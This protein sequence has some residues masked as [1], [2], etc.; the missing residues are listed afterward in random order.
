MFLEIFRFECRYQ[1][2]SP[3][4][5]VVAGL[6]F[7]I[8]FL[9]SGTDSVSVGGVGNNINLNANFAILQIQYTLTVLGLFPAVAFV[10]GAITR[11]YEAKTAQLLFASGVSE[12]SY[13]FGRFAGG[14]LFAALV[15]VAGL[16][17]TL[18]GTFMPWL[19]PE[20]MGPFTAAPYLFSIW[21]III[22]NLLII[23][24]LFFAVAALTRS[25]MAAYVAALGFFIAYIVVAN[26]TDQES[27]HL[28]AL[29]DPFGLTAFGEITRY[30]TVF[31]RN[32]GMPEVTSTLL[33]NRL[34]WAGVSLTVL[35]LAAWRYRFNLAPASRLRLRRKEKPGKPA[36][37]A[38]SELRAVQPLESGRSDVTRFFSQLRMDVRGMTRSIPFYVLLAF[39]MLQVVGS[40]IG[41]TTQF[42]GTP[43]YPLT[44]TLITF[45]GGSFSLA[46]IIVIIYYSGELVHRERQA[47]MH[48]IVDA[49]AYPNW[50]MVLSKVAAL[51]FVI[52][53][54][55]VVVMLT[56]MLVQIFNDFYRFE[57]P[58]YFKGLF[59]VLGVSY[60]L[61]CVPAVL[62]QVLSPNKFIGMVVF[63][64][65][66]LGLQTLP[67]LDFEHY[68]YQYATP[69]APY[70]DM[71]G[72]GHF[73]E[74]LVS[75]SIY[76]SALAGLMIVLAHLLFRRG[77]P[78]SARAQLT[79]AGGRWNGVVAGWTAV[80]A[81]VF[82]GCGAWIFYNTNVLN[83]YVTS[84]ARE[85]LQADYEKAYKQFEDLPM[86][87]LVDLEMAVDIYPES[88]RLDSRG[89]ARMV[90]RKAAPIEVLH[91][92]LPPPLTVNR[93]SL[94]GAA[95]ETADEA[96]DYYQYRFEEP[97]APGA[98]TTLE[99][100]LSWINEGFHNTGGT[101]RVVENGTFVNNTEIMP[102]PGYQS[103]RELGDNNVR[104]EYDLPPVER[105]PK[106]GD[107]DHLDEN[108]FTVSKRTAF[109]SVVSTAEDQIAVAPGYLQEE[110]VEGGRRYFAYEMDAPIWPFVS[111]SSARYAV[112]EDQW[113]DVK[114][115]VYYHPAHDFN[116]SNMIEGTKASLDYF[117]REFS[118]YQYRQFRILEFPRYQTFAQSFP[119]TIPYSEAIGF[120]ADLR[121]EKRIDYVFYV[122]AH[123][124]A[125]QWWGHQVVGANMQGATILVETLAQYSAL[126]VMEEAFGE[127]KMRRFLKYELDSYLQSRGSEL[128][129]ELPLNLVENQG[130]I[131]Y[132]KGS[133]AMYALK[134]AIGEDIVNLALR[135]LIA[136]WGFREGLFP[137]S[138]DL[139]AEFRAV[140]GPDHQDLITDL[141]EKIIVY[142]LSVA[143]TEV[144]EVDGGFEVTMIVEAAKFEADGAGQETEVALDQLLDVA[145][146]AEDTDEL[147]E[148]DL[149]P[150]LRFERVR[151]TSGEQTFTFTVSEQPGR[152]GI[153]PYVKM[154]D[155]NPDDNVKY[156]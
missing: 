86:P 19:D 108:Q 2:R 34:I 135:N 97:L 7:L 115:G 111:F 28:M 124:M 4:F 91:L 152:V 49:T 46:V 147:G 130:Y 44:G 84:D 32:F 153:D 39:G 54:M 56:A 10:A 8:A 88:R 104:R 37:A 68:L 38:R 143:D 72:Y 18:I 31:E 83:Q 122:T 70:S 127:E 65:I 98:E 92:S 118:P 140:A 17:G 52:A 136:K 101:T 94:A 24:A 87:E 57:I 6:W 26:V 48:E 81:I 89:T 21:A 11:D 148:D 95:L 138:M 35:L 47:N 16:L 85:K 42:F 151:I 137:T 99:W 40:T 59:G 134:D 133:L 64:A 53:T 116:V 51:W 1:L 120:V 154:I 22:P 141:F 93:L 102:L 75:F 36:P 50:I 58:L 74:R 71:N 60:F 96:H 67:S 103:S 12:L 107:P 5:L 142:D 149:P 66:F 155:R 132:R 126:M 80:F 110:W 76:W 125:H 82:F 139:V 128:I 25:M 119:N 77:Y 41:A 144:V 30:W 33:Y 62:V 105:A 114:I 106:L 117:T 63:L 29:G 61:L 13:F 20:R 146:F 145:V 113:N 69:P 79:V 109:R 15:G 27:I 123:E 23:S 156:L 43:V 45:V 100:D 90:N 121:D 14:A 55:L 129:E 112:A 3:L 131:H 150:A 73:V 9:I 78:G